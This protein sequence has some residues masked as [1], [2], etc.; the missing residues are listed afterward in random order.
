MTI[1]EI[2]TKSK[3]KDKELEGKE[4]EIKGLVKGNRFMGNVGFI[5]VHDGSCFESLQVVYSA[6][7]KLATSL[8]MGCSIIVKGSLHLTPEAKQI[9]E[10]ESKKIELI[11]DVSDDYVL[12]KQRMSFE[13]LRDIPQWRVRTNTFNA[14]FRIRSTLSYYIHDYFHKNGYLWIHTPIITG[15]DCEGEGQVFDVLAEGDKKGESQYFNVPNPH[16]TVSGQLHVEPFAL[17]Y[18]KVYT[19]GPTFRA[20]KSNTTRHAAEF[21]MIE[22]EIA[23]ADLDTLC[24]IEEE[25]LKYVVKNTIKDCES[26][27]N[28]FA[29]FVDKNLKTR[30]N[31][32]INQPFEFVEYTKCIDILKKAVKEGVKFENKDIDFGLDLNSEHE[33]YLTEVVYKKPIFLRN[34]PKDIK[35]FYM[36]INKDNKTVQAVDLLTPGIGELCG[37]SVREDSYDLLLKRINELKM[38]LESYKWYLDLRK[39]GSMPHAGFGLGFERLVMLVTGMDNIRDTQPYPRNYRNM[40]F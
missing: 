38:P 4:V 34:M 1:K 15:N 36:K 23:F 33:R 19:F 5:L 37:G 11:S 28:F 2:Y 31:E 22:P 8:R 7:D 32:F 6:K 17:A 10:L 39:N 16:L 21:W 30:L 14:L 3:K 35:A 20:E 25:F 24:N 27:I 40:L 26:D 12:Q 9:V 18:Q 13:Y 29:S